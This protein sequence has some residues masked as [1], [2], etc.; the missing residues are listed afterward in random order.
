MGCCSYACHFHLNNSDLLSSYGVI[1]VKPSGT[2]HT[3]KDLLSSDTWLRCL[4]SHLLIWAKMCVWFSN[5]ILSSFLK[6]GAVCFAS[7]LPL[8]LEEGVCP[9]D[10]HP[11]PIQKPS[12]AAPQGVLPCPWHLASLNGQGLVKLM[13][14]PNL[15]SIHCSLF[16]VILTNVSTINPEYF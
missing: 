6:A 14:L 12:L 11:V 4:L 5:C 15:S 9:S 16:V 13:N 1:H 7:Y 10:K 3:S 2:S 8:E